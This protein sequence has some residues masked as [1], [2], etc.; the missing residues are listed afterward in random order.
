MPYTSSGDTRAAEPG[1]GVDTGS[2]LPRLA[3][4]SNAMTRKPAVGGRRSTL[5][6][7]HT[8]LRRLRFE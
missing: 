4:P 1:A 6:H 7:E 3:R 8:Y 2:D 5:E